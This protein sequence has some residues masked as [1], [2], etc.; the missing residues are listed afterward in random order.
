MKAR[1]SGAEML[2]ALLIKLQGQH[3]QVLKK[4]EWLPVI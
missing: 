2:Y 1:P 3:C 4:T